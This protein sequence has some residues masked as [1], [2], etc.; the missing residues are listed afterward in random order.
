MRAN[1]GRDGRLAVLTTRAR[2]EERLIFAAFDR[3]GIPYVQVDDRTLIHHLGAPGVTYRGVLNRIMS[4]TRS[5]YATRLFE[6]T[7]HRVFNPSTVVDVCG[8]KILT[9]LAL[10]R[11]GLPTPATTVAITPDAALA[12]IEQVGYPAVIK[13]AVGSWGRLLSKVNDRDAAETLIEHKQSLRS[14]VHNVYYIQEYV[15]KPDRDIRVIVLGDEPVA[16]VYRRSDHWITNT[17][18]G[19]TTAAC[20]LTDEL[21]SLALRAAGAVGGGMLAVDLLERSTGELLVTEVN[22][23]MEFHGLAAVADVDLADLIVTHVDRALS[24]VDTLERAA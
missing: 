14:P 2:L 7:G 4:H 13:P 17:A 6:A 1:T 22:H 18:R 16:A 5:V 11:A 12:A 15:D 10:T 24:T 8:D 19:A 21:R 20:T 9:S 3:R 23:T